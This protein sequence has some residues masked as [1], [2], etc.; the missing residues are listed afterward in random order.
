MMN[1]N[2]THRRLLAIGLIVLAAVSPRLCFAGNADAA[3][4][5][6]REAFRRSEPV[7][8]ARAAQ[9]LDGHIL[10]PWADYWRL[11]LQLDERDSDEGVEAFIGR[12]EGTWLGNRMRA[13]WLRWLAA[14]NDA[15]K[16]RAVWPSLVDPDVELRCHAARI[17]GRPHDVAVLFVEGRDLPPACDDVQASLAAAGA[18]DEATVWQRVR[19]AQERK[20]LRTAA[21]ALAW[22]P[23]GEAQRRAYAADLERI[24]GAPQRWLDRLPANWAS[25]RTQR[26]L[27]LFAIAR[28]AATD[29][30]AAARR[31]AGLAERFGPEEAGYGWGQVA[32]AGALQHQPQ[33]VAW[34][35]KA[36]Q[37]VLTR[38][39]MAW[40]VRAALRGGDW[41][42]VR[43]AVAAMP[44]TM[45][46]ETDW[47]YWEGRALAALGRAEE[48]QAAFARIAGAHDFYGSLAAEELGRAIDPPRRAMGSSRAEIEA[49]EARPGVRRALAL[50][51]ADQRD[52]G[53]KEWAFATRGMD[54]R[55]LLA[56]AEVARAAQIWDRA[57][58]TAI[59]TRDEHDFGLRFL[60]PYGDTVR[61]RAAA[62]S[63]DDAWVYGLLRQESRFITQARSRVGA[64]G[65]MQVMPATA[66]WVA[67][68]IA[69][70]GYRRDA[71]DQL[72]TN[73]TL[74]T[75]YLRLVLDSLDNHPVL[76]SAAYN[77]GPGR[78]R[79]WRAEG[80]L[81]GAVYAETIPF[82][83]TRQYVKNVMNNAAY[84]KALFEGRPQS[85]KSLLGVVP[86]RRAVNAEDAALP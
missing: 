75:H 55:Q 56:A 78:A 11:A 50:F 68:K 36:E 21:Q 24:A 30:D 73:V 71:L 47:T 12:E 45:A 13:D 26:E 15:E 82:N 39:Q 38:E 79:R 48:A 32:T 20:A 31:F 25:H 52:E 86:P 60:A 5:E 49:A 85:L 35:G 51:R 61:P 41:L 67:K 57:I 10:Q 62:L 58:N 34:Y 1:Q 72:D 16:F 18:L 42:G 46:E 23:L 22:L 65:L 44:P 7:R 14:K 17:D 84:Y 43:M 3:F 81:E 19:R 76:A 69:L 33:A 66:K 54:D 9:R 77:A 29:A 37:T 4:A 83:E 80:A 8:L 6:A 74:G 70:P 27:A 63:L 53:V 64:Q 40:R 28:L 2:P 59:R